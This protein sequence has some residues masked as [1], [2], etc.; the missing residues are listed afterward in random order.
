MPS[1]ARDAAGTWPIPA[2]ALRPA[3]RPRSPPDSGSAFSLGDR[4][5]GRPS[6]ADRQGRFRADRQ[7]RTRAG[8]VA[9]RQSC[10]A[11][12]GRSPRRVL[13]HGAGEGGVV[14]S[15]RRTAVPSRAGR[16]LTGRNP[17]CDPLRIRCCRVHRILS[18]VR[19]DPRS[20]A[21][22]VRPVKVSLVSGS[23]RSNVGHC[24][25]VDDRR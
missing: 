13:Q 7:D 17:P 20:A 25:I 9:G 8:G 23:R 18:R 15:S 6:R 3:S 4:D 22:R 21:C 16:S 2:R 11:T 24:L 14:R 10:N 5:P 19:D 1:K 12:A